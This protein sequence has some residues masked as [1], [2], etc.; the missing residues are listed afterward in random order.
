MP[1]FPQPAIAVGLMAGVLALGGVVALALMGSRSEPEAQTPSG[2]PAA[3]VTLAQ[4]LPPEEPNI[5]PPAAEPETEVRNGS[6]EDLLRGTLEAL[7]REDRAW[8]A[9]TLAST[10]GR[11]LTEDDLHAAYRQFLWRSAQPMWA[12]VRSAFEAGNWRISE[13][14]DAGELILETGGALGEMRIELKKIDGSW[15]YAGV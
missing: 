8:L 7:V 1:R 14:A 2:Q 15:H 6:I 10:A 13:D 11:D 3:E 4:Q 12:R 9:R 5:S